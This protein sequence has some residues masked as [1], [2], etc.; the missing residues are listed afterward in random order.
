MSESWGA[1][2]W[3]VDAVLV[4]TVIELAALIVYHRRTGRGVGFSDIGL[5]LLSGL[6][7]MLAL[8]FAL[9]NTG[10][11]AVMAALAVAGGLHLSDLWARWRR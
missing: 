3:L 1:L 7:L 9:S 8:R 4:L 6:A 10:S 2:V 11:W 5:N